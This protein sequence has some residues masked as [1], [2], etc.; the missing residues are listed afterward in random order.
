MVFGVVIV[1]VLIFEMMMVVVVFMGLGYGVFFI[2]GFVFVV[3]LLFD[4]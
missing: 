2:V 4:E 1:F 3:D